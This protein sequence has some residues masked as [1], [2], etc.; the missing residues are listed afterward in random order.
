MVAVVLRCRGC[1][2]QVSEWAAVCP[3]C[4][5]PVADAVVFAGQRRSAGRKWLRITAGGAALVGAV[6]AVAL[7]VGSGQ[8]KGGRTAAANPGAGGATPA[9]VGQAAAHTFCLSAPLTG[10]LGY[11]PDQ[12]SGDA[13]PGEIVGDVGGF[14]P[15]TYV[16]GEWI[17]AAGTP[18]KTVSQ[19]SFR[20]D[21][22]GAQHFRGDNPSFI[23]AAAR[24][25]QVS[26]RVGTSD[27]DAQ[28]Y[29]PSAYPCAA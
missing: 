25:T 2:A 14:P 8:A 29:G 17:D 27:R 16:L 15:S 13:N 12:G 22:T 1:G 4:G 3:A 19:I 9:R 26:F 23:S 11:T 24:V 10:R 21:S 5:A 18:A 6:A 7:V 28:P 20:T